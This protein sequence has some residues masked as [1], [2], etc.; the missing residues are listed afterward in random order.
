M[1]RRVLLIG[2][3]L[4]LAVLGTVAVLAYVGRADTRALAG[5]RAVTV[6]VAAKKVSAGTSAQDADRDGLFK[7]EQMPA[8]TVPAD[9]LDGVDSAVA[10]LV[11]GADIEAG[12]LVRRPM[13]VAKKQQT[14]GLD[15]PDGKIAVTVAV[16]APQEV[17]G[18]L[19]TG[20]KIAIFDTFN[21][22]EG[23]GRTPAGDGLTKQ[24]NYVQ[25]TRLLLTGVKV[26]SIGAASASTTDGSSGRALAAGTTG[27][28]DTVLVTVAVNQVEA[29]K[30]VHGA[31][32]GALYL[33]L[34]TDTSKTEPG[35]GVDNHT[36]FG[37]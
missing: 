29:E 1:S 31:Q 9:T 2:S 26:L 3:A 8:E 6:L 25:A 22:M 32:T 34:L 11:A 10:G 18:Y 21:T 36:V 27:G 33:A 16:G 13:F 35:D 17:A 7:T 15:I 20:S 23:A 4:L 30:L 37:N 5:K 12:Q 24:H 19:Q 28:T 14:G